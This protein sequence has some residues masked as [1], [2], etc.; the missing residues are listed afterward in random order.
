MKRLIFNNI[1]VVLCAIGLVRIVSA[2]AG[3]NATE[4]GFISQ[5]NSSILFPEGWGFFTKSPREEKYMLY[6]VLSTGQLYPIHRNNSSLK[7]WLGLS[8]GSRRIN[9]EITK[10]A[11]A[12]ESDSIWTKIVD[13]KLVFYKSLISA[14]RADTIRFES[15][16]YHI[17]KPGVYILKR[18]QLPAW[19]W[20]KYEQH[21]TKKAFIK[22]VVLK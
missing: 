13:G 6:K 16:Q 9:M 4:I 18:Y 14:L 12:T 3:A 17:I 10:I 8:R 21:F 20:A 11:A 22:K 2:M 15:T 5:Y 7:N 19:L 1:I